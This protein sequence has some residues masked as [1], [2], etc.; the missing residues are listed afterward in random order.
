M[1]S[2]QSKRSSTRAA[3][4][5]LFAGMLLAGAYIATEVIGLPYLGDRDFQVRAD[6]SMPKAHATVSLP[7][8]ATAHSVNVLAEVPH[9]GLTEHVLV[10]AWHIPPAL[11]AFGVL[12]LL[13]RLTV[14]VRHGDP[15]TDTN[16]RR[17]RLIGGSLLIATPVLMVS[18]MAR[19]E[20]ASRSV[21]GDIS[22]FSVT[23][24]LVPIVAGLLVFVFAEVF[25]A[26]VRMRRDVEGLV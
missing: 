19:T 17:L 9:V 15:F 16:V 21:V 1:E 25:A 4:R 23:V 2:V 7:A 18:E 8:G 12:F 24:T 14:S 13:Y 5:F 3:S 20:L 11:L 10:R 6:V 22:T 26:G